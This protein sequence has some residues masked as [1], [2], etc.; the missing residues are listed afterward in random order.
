MAWKQEASNKDIDKANEEIKVIKADMDK[1]NTYVWDFLFKMIIITFLQVTFYEKYYAFMKRPYVQDRLFFLWRPQ[2]NMPL[3]NDLNASMINLSGSNGTF[4]EFAEINQTGR[5]N[6][7]DMVNNTLT[8]LTTIEKENIE[9]ESSQNEEAYD[10]Q[11]H[12]DEQA[13]AN[14]KWFFDLVLPATLGFLFNQT[15]MRF[16][17]AIYQQFFQKKCSN[18]YAK[19]VSRKGVVEDTSVSTGLN[20]TNERISEHVVVYNTIL[21]EQVSN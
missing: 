11:K 16:L 15:V 8:N 4:E 19:Y 9:G 1:R 10:P 14:V 3:N 17:K 7:T 5:L 13:H 18:F 6:I 12:Y 20:I 2:V 21:P